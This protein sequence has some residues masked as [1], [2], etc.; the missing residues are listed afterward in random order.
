MNTDNLILVVDDDLLILSATTRLL[1]KAGYKVI[2]AQTS[3]DALRSAKEHIP[4][5]ILLDNVLP[6]MD[7]LEICRRLKVD[8]KTSHIFVCIISGLKITS[9]DQS[10]GLE[11]GADEY[12]V[13]PI[14]NRELLARVNSMFRLIRAEKELEKHRNHLESLVEE[15]TAE[16][17]KAITDLNQSEK[18]LQESEERFRQ[19]YNHMSTGVAKVSLEFKIESAN[20]AY[21]KMLGY[22]EEELLGKHLRE[23]THP[24]FLE[25]NLL[26]QS[27]LAA[28]EIDHFRMEKRF[29]HKND[30]I[31]YGMLDASLVRDCD[32]IPLYFLGSVSDIT[33]RK[34]AEEALRES[35]EKYRSMMDSMKDAAYIC[36]PELLIQYMNPRMIS[37]VGRD[38][39]GDYCYKAIY[40]CDEKCSWCVLD[41]VLQ[42]EHIDYDLANPKDNRFYS[43][44]NSPIYHSGGAISN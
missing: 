16:L 13:R 32:G 11:I 7:G 34:R 44:T 40:G 12:L 18:T 10:E 14:A 36:S 15:R 31:V 17:Q 3:D 38:A 29:I 9:K 20:P 23:I 4:D 21:C 26:K 30:K 19:V 37:T 2:E 5:L 1:K 35:E 43:V 39:T 6:D 28:G 22:H 42:G 25:K 33:D 24:D 41:N 27:Q 8:K